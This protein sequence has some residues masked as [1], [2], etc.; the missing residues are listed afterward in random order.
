M[1]ITRQIMR[2]AGIDIYS[3]HVFRRPADAA[4]RRRDWS[5]SLMP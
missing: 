2:L 1:A 5:A 4:R 3:A